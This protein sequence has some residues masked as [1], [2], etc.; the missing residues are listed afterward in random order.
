[1]KRPIGRYWVVLAI[2]ALALAGC[3]GRQASGVPAR[4]IAFAPVRHGPSSNLFLAMLRHDRNLGPVKGTQQV[5]FLVVLRRRNAAQ[6]QAALTAIYDPHSPQY[7]KFETP[8]EWAARYGPSPA[9]VQSA[10]QRLAHLGLATGWQPGSTSMQISGPARTIERVFAVSVRWYR[11]AGGQRF[12]ASGRDPRVPAWLRPLV[13]EVGHLSSYGVS[14]LRPILRPARL[15]PPDGLTPS[16]MLATYDIRPLRQAGADGS[17]QTIAFIEL[18]GYHQSDLDAF[19][20]Q[21]NL[22]AMHPE[23]KYGDKLTDVSGETELDMEVAHEIA[24]GAR[25][26]LYNCSSTCTSSDIPAV[27]NAAAKDNPKS[28]ISVS[29]G[30]CE[31]AEGSS[32]A[33]AENSAFQQAD[34]LG[35]SAFVASG[36]SGAFECLTQNWGAPPTQQYVGLSCPACTPSVTAVGGTHVSLNQN[37]SYYREEAWED[38]LQT[39]GTGGGVS[40]IFSRPSWQTGPGTNSPYNT[41]NARMVPDVAADADP[42]T[43]AKIYVQG[44][45]VEVGGTSQATPIWAGITALMNQYL[46]SH[47]GHAA[48]F[49]NPAVYALAANAP[50]YPPFRDVTIGSNLVYP[51]GPGYDLA[52]GVGTPDVWNL[53]RDLAAYQKGGH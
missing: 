30:G 52:T 20:K 7:G 1:M 46:E 38:P 21:F 16:D 24:P 29:L 43:S 18:D 26:L 37:G 10:R 34:A 4:T 53:V 5:S 22:P 6:Q 44:S 28:I 49:L 27:E 45:F 8:A 47:G 42:L 13:T 32:D 25:L 48:G 17:G 2:G 3:A 40:T 41:N 50:R 51:A 33:H 12:W 39:A 35:E 31:L 9:A 14:A 11:A 19:T 23:I 15:V 36:D